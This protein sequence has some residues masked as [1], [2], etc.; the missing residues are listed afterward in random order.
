V[1]D[2]PVADNMSLIW[3]SDGSNLHASGP[4]ERN[5]VPTPLMVHGAGH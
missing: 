4:S 1:T 5:G 2:P 3:N